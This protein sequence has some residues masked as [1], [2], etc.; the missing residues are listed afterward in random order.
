[1]WH[2]IFPLLGSL[3]GY[4]RQGFG[5]FKVYKETNVKTFMLAKVVSFLYRLMTIDFLSHILIQI[6]IIFLG[7][8]VIFV[9]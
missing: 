1:M 7:N 3:I 4:S 6:F 9:C 2:Q 8:L 5:N